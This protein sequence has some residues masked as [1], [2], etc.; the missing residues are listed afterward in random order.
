[1]RS[2][3]TALT[4]GVSVT[5]IAVTAKADSDP[6]APPPWTEYGPPGL[7]VSLILSASSCQ[8][9]SS[10]WKWHST[11]LQCPLMTFTHAYLPSWHLHHVNATK[12]GKLTQPFCL[13][14]IY[15]M[16]AVFCLTSFIFLPIKNRQERKEG[17]RKKNQAKEGCEG[18]DE[19][20]KDTGGKSVNC[21]Y[22]LLLSE[23]KDRRGGEPPYE[24]AARIEVDKDRWL[25]M[26]A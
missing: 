18:Q 16:F 3:T 2:V 1:M 11:P 15:R 13:C 4:S 8:L 10:L 9:G 19:V 7:C 17:R 5:Q 21:I 14:F 12:E 25:I 23:L 20:K 24:H 22:T 26:I 6:T